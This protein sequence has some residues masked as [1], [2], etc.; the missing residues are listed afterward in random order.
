MLLLDAASSKW[1]RSLRIGKGDEARTWF[2]SIVETSLAKHVGGRTVRFGAPF[3]NDWPVSFSD[4]V[5]HLAGLFGLGARTNEIDQLS[6][7]AQQDDSLD[8]V[9]R[10]NFGDEESATPYLLVQCATGA[11]WASHK[12]GEPR[13]E[14]WR[15]YIAWDG[16]QYKC[17]AVPFVLRERGQLERACFGHF[18][19]IILDRIRIAAAAPDEALSTDLRERLVA[20]CRAQLA[21]IPME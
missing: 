2:E 9:A 3:P 10:L 19:A 14:L 4:R 13:M 12:Q 21:K 15:R 11:N 18:S 6:S 8:I 17:L 16:P 1:Y 20:W 5:Q 7:R